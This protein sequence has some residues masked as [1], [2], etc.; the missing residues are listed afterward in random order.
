MCLVSALSISCAAVPYVT[1]GE[2]GGRLKCAP[3]AYFT[4]RKDGA[5][6]YVELITSTLTPV[7]GERGREWGE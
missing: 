3:V 1:T 7:H 5:E 2:P 4:G 6:I